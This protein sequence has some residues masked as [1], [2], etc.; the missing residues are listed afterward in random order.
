MFPYVVKARVLFDIH[1]ET[2]PGSVTS[3]KP[4]A[5]WVDKVRDIVMFAFAGLLCKLIEFTTIVMS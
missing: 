2:A 5:D 4:G 1:S 3:S